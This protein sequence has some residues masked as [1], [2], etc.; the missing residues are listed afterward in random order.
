MEENEINEKDKKICYCSKLNKYFLF[1]FFTPILSIISSKTIIYLINN[2]DF[3]NIDYF[4]SIYICLSLIVGGLSYFISLIKSRQDNKNIAIINENLSTSKN[5]IKLIYNPKK[6]DNKTVFIILI[7]MSFLFALNVFYGQVYVINYTVLDTRFYEILFISLL[8][9]IIL[10][11]ELYRH[12]IF[13]ILISFIGFIFLFIPI[14]LII[15][16][17]DLLINIILIFNSLSYSLHLVLLKYITCKYFISPYACCFIIGIYSTIFLL[18]ILIV[19][20]LA[21]NGDLSNLSN[22]FKISITGKKIKF[23]GLLILSHIIYSITQY[24]VYMTIYFF[25]PMIFI[26]TQIIYPLLRYTINIIEG[27]DYK[28]F[29]LIFNIIGYLILLFAISIYHET[30]IL[31]FCKLNQDTKIFIVKR[32]REE[33]Y[34]MNNDSNNIDKRNDSEYE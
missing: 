8:S 33:I 32:Q 25:S 1:P 15:T 5:S 23:Y 10:K 26:I 31:N 29:D 19:H 9:K 14:V 30:I 7:L 3:G 27:Q 28:V 6:F 4:C 2:N 17:K 20:S 16:R 24:L 12:Q 22:S 18:I 11:K 21:I 34:L 13:S